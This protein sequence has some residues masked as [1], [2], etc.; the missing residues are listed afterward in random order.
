MDFVAVLREKL[1]EFG[2]LITPGVDPSAPVP[3]CGDWTF[4]DLVDHVGQGNL[5]VTTAVLEQR[6]DFQG[7]P[8]PKDP[9]ELRA[10]YDGTVKSILA[11]VSVDSETPAWTFTS[12][13]PRKVGFWQRRRAQE[14]LMHLWDAQDA[15]GVAEAFEPALAADGVTEVFELFAPRM[16][17]R[18]LASESTAAVGLRATDTGDSWTYGPGTP[19]AEISGAASDLLLA[20]WQRKELK[21]S[22]FSWQGNWAEGERVLVGPLV[23]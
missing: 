6:G 15:L 11:A 12:Q 3:S 19:V 17:L 22:A 9:V 21:D 10:W 16:V 13:M 1:D 14:T 20:L 5:W 18:G 8:A 4:Y 7:D 2:E 23:P